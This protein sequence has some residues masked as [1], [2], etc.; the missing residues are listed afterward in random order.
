MKKPAVNRQYDA[1]R[2]AARELEL[3]KLGADAYR[4]QLLKAFDDGDLK[5]W[6]EG[7]RQGVRDAWDEQCR[8]V[9]VTTKE[10]ANVLM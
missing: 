3:G 8:N 5:P 6:I 4:R 2:H 10:L 9:K 1:G 7:A